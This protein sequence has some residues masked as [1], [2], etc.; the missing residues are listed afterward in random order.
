MHAAHERY[1]FNLIRNALVDRPITSQ[2]LLVPE[3]I[4][5]SQEEAH[6]LLSRSAN[7]EKLGFSL[8]PFGA[9]TVL[10]RAVPSQFKGKSVVPFMREI[11]QIPAEEPGIGA[12]NVFRERLDHIAARM[13]C[14]ASVRSGFV[15]APEEIRALFASLD[16]T[17]FS[18]ACPHG[19][20][21]IV[22]Y[23]KGEVERWFGRDR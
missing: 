16:S 7:L 15:M 18:A 21:V 2:S 13:A 6:N 5:L 9:D 1:N 14:H 4:K 11:G 3:T 12:E 17:E 23:T 20:P 22:S 19:R 8:E 10:V